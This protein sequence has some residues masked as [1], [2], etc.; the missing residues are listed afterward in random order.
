[1]KKVCC[2]SVM[3]MKSL[4]KRSLSPWDYSYDVE[5][6]RYP[7][8]IAI[9]KCRHQQCVD[10][11]GKL[12]DS[13][14]SVEIRQEILVLYREMKDCKPTYRLQKKMVT[15]G[16]TCVQPITTYIMKVKARECHVSLSYPYLSPLSPATLMVGVRL[17]VMHKTCNQ[18]KAPDPV[19]RC[20]AKL[21]VPLQNDTHPVPSHIAAGP[22][23]RRRS[24]SPWDYSIDEEPNRYPSRIAIAKC[25]HQRCVDAE[26]KLMDSGNSVEIRQEILVL[27]REMKDCK[28]TYR[29]QKK[30]V[31]VGCTCVRSIIQHL[32]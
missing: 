19:P 25:R 20:M 13:G 7:S 22:D 28:P 21:K 9:A 32:I 1:H 24:L 8:R 30:M 6:T 29:L 26:G 31:T 18:L 4:R 3:P 16:C 12:M 23:V 5:P 11:D 14:N 15:V 2:N 17:R 27:Y 10:A